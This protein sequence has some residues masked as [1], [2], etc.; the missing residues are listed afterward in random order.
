MDIFEYDGGITMPDRGISFEAVTADRMTYTVDL[1][2][3]SASIPDSVYVYNLPWGSSGFSL[4]TGTRD[5]DL[6]GSG[7]ADITVTWNVS[8]PT[9]AA[10]KHPDC[11]IT[12]GWI[13]NGTQGGIYYG[14][15]GV[16]FVSG[17]SADVTFD[18]VRVHDCGFTGSTGNNKLNPVTQH[19]LCTA[20][21]KLTVRNGLFTRAYGS[22]QF[23]NRGGVLNVVNC[24]V[25]GVRG[26]ATSRS[27]QT[28]VHTSGTTTLRNTIFWGNSGDATHVAS[29]ATEPTVVCCDLEA[30][31]P[32]FKNATAGDYH[33]KPSS[34]VRDRGDKTGYTRDDVD[35]D[36]DRRVR[37]GFPDLGCFESSLVGTTVILR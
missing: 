13:A 7:K 12:G 15:G 24:T 3:G 26:L 16:A 4:P 34:P 35:L 14:V 31:D 30:T 6:D 18:R 36:H 9:A 10:V 20:G 1:R 23:C 37:G 5:I 27:Q 19:D 29:G 17:A 22:T 28:L 21:G 2:G 32:L 33:L 11:D 8:D 25:T